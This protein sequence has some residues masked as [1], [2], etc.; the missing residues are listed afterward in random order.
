MFV[1]LMGSGEEI[2][3]KNRIF[4]GDPDPTE[5][6]KGVVADWVQ[7]EYAY[8]ELNMLIMGFDAVWG[9]WGDCRAKLLMSGMWF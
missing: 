3:K 6:F 5:V 4:W 2:W 8:Y 9:I 7:I 1:F